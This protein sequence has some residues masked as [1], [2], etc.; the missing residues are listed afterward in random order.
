MNRITPCLWFDN[1]AEEAVNFYCSVFK[2][3]KVLNMSRYPEVGPGKPGSVLTAS[4]EIDGQPLTALNGGPQF[5][6][7]EAISLMVMCDTQQEIDDYWAKLTANGGKESQCG[8]LKDKYG[9]S[10]QIVPRI[11]PQLMQDK[12]PAK[13]NRV[14]K[15]LLK[16]VK[17][18]IAGLQRAYDQQE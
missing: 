11:L 17:L 2:N 3:S 13:R 16:M 9:L 7:T 10:W 1:N 8:W 5:T 4:F 14:M 15:A 6:F 12:D 18:D